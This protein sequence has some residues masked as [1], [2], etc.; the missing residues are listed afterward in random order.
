MVVK[1]GYEKALEN[2]NKHPKKWEKALFHFIYSNRNTPF[3]VDLYYYPETH[4][5]W[6]FENPGGNSWLQ[7]D[8]ITVYSVN[9]EYSEEWGPGS[10]RDTAS[11]YKDHISD[12][13]K[14]IT[15][16]LGQKARR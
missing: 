8:H 13:I 7:D 10:I 4:E 1:N 2:I 14:Q 16:E 12:V 5:F 15:E 6:Q 11:Y 9:N 3:Q